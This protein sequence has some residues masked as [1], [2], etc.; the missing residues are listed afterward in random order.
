MFLGERDQH[1]L[2]LVSSVNLWYRPAG[3][4][5]RSPDVTSMRIHLSALSL[6]SKYPLPSR[7]N[8]TS[9]SAWR[10]S[11]KKIF[12][13]RGRE[14]GREGERKGGRE[15]GRKGEGERE[16][17]TN[18]LQNSSTILYSIPTSYINVYVH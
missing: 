11:S 8:R 6:T 4:I 9:S 18:P 12:I 16:R 5:M 13:W 1:N 15:G 7:M 2:T 17:V 10:C 14:G 3:S